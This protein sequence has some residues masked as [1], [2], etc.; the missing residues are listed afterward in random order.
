MALLRAWLLHVL[1]LPDCVCKNNLIFS[2]MCSAT[3]ETR[4]AVAVRPAGQQTAEHLKCLLVSSCD[5]QSCCPGRCHSSWRP[6]SWPRSCSL[7]RW[8]N[9]GTLTRGRRL[10]GKMPW[11][12]GYRNWLC[13]LGSTLSLVCIAAAHLSHPAVVKRARLNNP[14]LR[15]T[16]S[17]WTE[18]FVQSG[19]SMDQSFELH[20]GL[21]LITFR[22]KVSCANQYQRLRDFSLPDKLPCFPDRHKSCCLWHL[23]LAQRYSCSC[24]GGFRWQEPEPLA[25]GKHWAKTL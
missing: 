12:K 16:F 22:K 1:H 6:Q 10:R 8:S 15:K 24:T 20:V 2:D 19:Q 9:S 13:Q 17:P 23:H 18:R 11:R 25:V 21:C 7:D 5:T 4:G 3:A 14:A